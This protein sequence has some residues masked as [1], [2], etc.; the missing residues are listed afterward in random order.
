MKLKNWRIDDDLQG[1]T[2]DGMYDPKCDCD[3]AESVL[4]VL[5]VL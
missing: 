1:M 2:L 3:F 5:G 4:D